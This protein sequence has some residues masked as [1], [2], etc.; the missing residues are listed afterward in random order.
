MSK[1]DNQK[2]LGSVMGISMSAIGIV[3]VF[4]MSLNSN[5]KK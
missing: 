1:K 4:F 2:I 3:L 5:R